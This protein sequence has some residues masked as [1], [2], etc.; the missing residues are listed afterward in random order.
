MTQMGNEFSNQVLSSYRSA[1]ESKAEASAPLTA[2]AGQIV[3]GHPRFADLAVGQSSSC[4]MASVFLDLTNFTARTFWDDPE[5]MTR[6]AHAVLSGFTLVVKR[7]GGHVL[8]LRGDGLFAGFGPAPQPEAVVVVAAA[9]CAAALDA[10]RNYLNP[11]LK[12]WGIEPVQA[13][14]GAD[15]GKATFVRSGT[16]TANEINIVGF[17]SNFAAKCEKAAKSWELVVGEGFAE[18]INSPDLLTAHEDS[19]KRYSRGTDVRRYS[20]YQ[21]SW[22]RILPEID[23]AMSE[24]SGRPLESVLGRI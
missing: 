23:S 5:D 6:L 16:P 24:I 21:H 1:V 22:Q 10:T 14:A 4:D 12:T 8:G 11:Q 17:A 15:Y 18:Y 7:F 9:A 2:S 3:T 20:Y 13:R 19:P